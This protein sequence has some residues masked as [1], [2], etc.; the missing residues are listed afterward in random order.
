MNLIHIFFALLI[1]LGSIACQKKVLSTYEVSSPGN[2]IRAQFLL[3]EAGQPGYRVYFKDKV[4][5]DS[6]FIAIELQDA[7]PLRYGW[8]VTNT[9]VSSFDETWHPIWGEV[10]EIRNRYNELWVALR[11]RT[12]PNRLLHLRFRVYDDGLGF[13]Y[14][15]PEQPNLSEVV[16]LDE[17]TEFQ[18]TGDHLTWWQ[19]GDWDIYEHLYNK[20]RFT[21]IDALAKRDHPN[22]AQTY[23]PENAVNTPVTM[24]T[25]DGIYLS[26][27]EAALYNYSDMTLLVDKDKLRWVSELVGNAENIKVR[28]RTPFQTPWRTIQIADRAG[29]LIESHLIVNLNE[30]NVLEDI[31]W[32]QPMKYVGIWWEMHLGKSTWQYQGGKHGATT[33][34]AKRHIDFAAA[35]G[36]KGLLVEGWNT[37]WERWIGFEDREGVFDFVTPYPDYDIE[38]V[39]RYAREKGVQLIMHHETSSAVRTYEQ[40]MDTAFA[41]CQK[42]GIHSVKTGYVGKIIPKG[43]Y[44]HGQYMVNHYQKV[45]ETAARYKVAVNAHEPIKDTGIRRTWPSFVAREGLR[46]Q[47]FNSWSI[48][49]GN[50]VDHLPN[51]MFTRM[52]AGPIDYTPGVFN[53]LLKPYRN[54][55]GRVNH[56][57]AQELALYVVIYSPIQMVADLLENYENQPGLQFIRDVAVDWDATKVL[58]GEPGDYVTIARKAKGSDNWFMG[59]ITN[60]TPRSFSFQ[61]DFLDAGKTYKA[62]LYTDAPDADWKKNPTAMNISERLIT[63]GDTLP[64]TL[65]AGGGAAVHFTP[66][67]AEEITRLSR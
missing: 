10:S 26:F 33:A 13:R 35:N 55:E 67:T 2:S 14:E 53:L 52:L 11:E 56:T 23:I 57:L 21:E 37:G 64:L 65:V 60:G 15:F 39:V 6:S 36:I 16:I 4:V 45:L 42:L 51:V 31:T 5:I 54:G 46:G 17:L 41:L 58:N 22:L 49:K 9:A 30:P 8:E 3:S 63:R 27:H 43:E 24:K 12:A 20:T 25:D 66:A 59:S 7:L 19:P 47:E 48:E 62:I 61:L 34:N 32:I 40:Q 1:T 50:P 38:E 29:D 18:L 28:T 44:H